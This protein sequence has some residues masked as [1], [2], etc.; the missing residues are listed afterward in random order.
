ML[1]G[2]RISIIGF[3]KDFST[4]DAGRDPLSLWAA[5]RQIP[6]STARIEANEFLGLPPPSLEMVAMAYTTSASV[7]AINQGEAA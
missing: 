4:D 5:A 3:W 2:A 6:R 1:T 7:D